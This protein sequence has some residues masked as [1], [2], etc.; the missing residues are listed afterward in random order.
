MKGYY[1]HISGLKEGQHEYYFKIDS[2]FFEEFEGSEIKDCSL[3]VFAILTQELNKLSLSLQINGTIFN[4]LCDIC[5]SKMKINISNLCS[6]LL[7]G[8]DLKINNWDEGE[9]DIIYIMPEQQ[10][11]NIS[12]LIYESIILSIPTKKTHGSELFNEKCDG[13]MISLI[14]K[15]SEKKSIKDPRWKDLD[16]LKDLI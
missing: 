6:F 2:Q 15:Y 7:K 13:N 9:E 3:E 4:L 8:E 10:K 12:K 16:K 1:I 11:I 14:N 5:N